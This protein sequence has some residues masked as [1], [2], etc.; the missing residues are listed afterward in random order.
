MNTR[1]KPVV[2]VVDDYPQIREVAALA[3]RNSFTVITTPDGPTALSLPGT[4][5]TPVI[6]LTGYDTPQVR[7]EASASGGND[8]TTLKARIALALYRHTGRPPH[9]ELRG[10]QPER[11]H[12]APH[13]VE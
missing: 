11:K 12:H 4:A 5:D 7:R 6:F 3:L 9:P 8:L 2:L 10:R 1:I 13:P